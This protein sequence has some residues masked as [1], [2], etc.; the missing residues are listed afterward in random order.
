MRV[1][2]F[3]LVAIALCCFFSC[4]KEGA[5]LLKNSNKEVFWF[6]IYEPSL[7]LEIGCGRTSG[8]PERISG[9]V[10]PAYY[11]VSSISAF[12]TDS[13][14]PFGATISPPDSTGLIDFSSPKQFTVTAE[15]GTDTTFWVT[16]GTVEGFWLKDGNIVDTIKFELS[17]AI[18]WT[19][20]MSEL[21]SNVF[22]FKI[23]KP[24]RDLIG[25][26]IYDWDY[27][28]FTVLPKTIP[29]T[30]QIQSRQIG[31]ALNGGGQY[32]TDCT[33]TI[34]ELDLERGVFSGNWN[35]S[36]MGD[37]ING[38]VGSFKNAPLYGDY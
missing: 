7:S 4:K 5:V 21:T 36:F 30:P 11:G 19:F 27:E 12:Y 15:D 38:S 28:D 34:T 10:C 32:C 37:V 1:N 25:E 6:S 35:L 18:D 20:G 3:I 16:V 22:N 29:F 8:F 31:C 17:E 9:L 33:L 13:R 2:T 23:G 24:C 26:G 14:L